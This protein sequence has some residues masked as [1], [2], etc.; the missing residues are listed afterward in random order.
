MNQLKEITTK[1]EKQM[2]KRN[3]GCEVVMKKSLNYIQKYI[4]FLFKQNVIDN[5]EIVKQ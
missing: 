1:S 3:D 5:A 4:N 2:L